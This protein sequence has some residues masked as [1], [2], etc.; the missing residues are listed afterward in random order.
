MNSSIL[1]RFSRAINAAGW[2]L[3]A[4]SAALAFASG[5]GATV[6]IDTSFGAYGTVYSPA[7]Q[8]IESSAL[9]PDGRIVVAGAT[10]NSAPEISVARF[11]AD[12]SPDVLFGIGGVV[13]DVVPGADLPGFE[14]AR[15]TDVAVQP[16]RK[17]VVVGRYQTSDQ[18]LAAIVRL[19]P[20]GTPDTDFGDGGRVLTAIQDGAAASA[21]QVASNGDILVGGSSN[22]LTTTGLFALRLD[23]N[24]D[25]VNSFGGDGAATTSASNLML[26]AADVLEDG[27]GIIVAAGRVNPTVG[28]GQMTLTRFKP[29]GDL[30]SSYGTG[31]I[32]WTTFPEWTN[33]A[34]AARTPD[35]RVVLVGGTGSGFDIARFT[36]SGQ[37]DPTYSS[38]GLVAADF[39]GFA[40]PSDV[41][42]RP[43][44]KVIAVGQTGAGTPEIA[45]YG[46]TV[47]GSGD[48]SFGTAGRVTTQLPL[49]NH[50]EG[51]S[52]LIDASGRLLVVGTTGYG[53]IAMVRYLVDDVVPSL[54][55]RFPAA[56]RASRL[57][58]LSGSVAG[59]ADRVQVAV[60][61]NLLRANRR[62]QWLSSSKAK[63][64][65]IK[66][67][68]GCE[69]QVWLGTELSADGHW[70]LKLKRRLPRGSYTVFIRAVDTAGTQKVALKRSLR[71]K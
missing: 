25:P 27:E 22:A 69:R 34:R 42:L 58:V 41:V 33:A 55:V 71:L 12:G 23:V 1:A 21:V 3:A 30:D 31:G 5:A 4:A 53:A 64:T 13:A 38:D 50:T 46:T 18:T 70:K 20:D 35:G 47:D 26:K 67:L 40:V 52:G 32:A 56:A 66:R 24:G 45:M 44:G 28:L 10:T 63:F 51:R 14:Q 17:I 7:L 43:N 15:A 65:K 60:R 62:C 39:N 2:L 61:R 49:T 59:G 19:N 8:L 16:D 11:T 29:D 48:V 9:D 36:A 6:K 68:T 57:K 37:L 54:R